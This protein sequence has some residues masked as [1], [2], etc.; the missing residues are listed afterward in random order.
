MRRTKEWWAGLSPEEHS[1]LVALEQGQA[2]LGGGTGWNLPEGYSGCQCGYPKRG[3]G[4]CQLC[5]ERLQELIAKADKELEKKEQLYSDQWGAAKRM[6]N[7]AGL[8]WEGVKANAAKQTRE[9][10]DAQEEI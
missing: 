10:P 8:F 4:L 6:L 7:L 3:R 5:W 1:K 9:E 2:T